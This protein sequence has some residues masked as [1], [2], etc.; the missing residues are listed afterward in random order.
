MKAL[1]VDDSRAMRLVLTN[2]LKGHGFEVSEAPH[3]RAALDHLVKHADTVLALIDWNMPEMTGIELLCA[4][5][6]DQRFAGMKRV[7]VTTESETS[8]VTQAAANG[9]DGF[10]L[11]PFTKPIVEDKLRS[12][13]LL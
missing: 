4:L 5:K 12:L 6:G 10:I 2:I 3:G 7:M 8:H 13:G 9:A 1:V 11:K